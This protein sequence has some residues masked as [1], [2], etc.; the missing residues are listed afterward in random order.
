MDLF[1]P[2]ELSALI[3]QICDCAL[4][5]TLWPSAL[6]NIAE[7]FNAQNAVLLAHDPMSGDAVFFHQWGDDPTRQLLYA[8]KYAP[9]NPLLTAGWF[10]EID[11][12]FC[13]NSFMDPDEFRQTR[14]FK[15]FAAPQG[16]CDIVGATLQKSAQ[17][18][19]AVSATR[20]ETAGMAGEDEL[21]LMGLLAPHLRRAVAIQDAFDAQRQKISDL[22]SALDLTSSA[23]FLLDGNGRCTE[24][25]G[26]AER[27]LADGVASLRQTKLLFAEESIRKKIEGALLAA[28]TNR[29]TPPSSSD[30]L[31][32]S[33]GRRYVIEFLPLNSAVREPAGAAVLALFL[34]E[35]GNLQPLPGEALVKLYGLTPAETRLLVL[36][37]QSMTL[38]EA[39][40]TLGI[41]K[42]TAR[43]HLRQVFAKTG[44]SRQAEVVRLVMSCLPQPP[45]QQ[46]A[47]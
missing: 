8:E 39:A 21:A 15:E 45:Q 7:T 26:A 44:C 18:Y 12:A 22:R 10:A 6:K 43:A 20:D 31:A 16:W 38:D 23:I 1:S 29:S 34:Q 36:L 19:T 17:R 35:V 3:G 30:A 5:T 32:L 24:A 33:S 11:R 46:K 4:D 28:T 2:G 40:E 37:A 42:G 14:F 41:T 13:V 25:N 27:C 47:N 9:I